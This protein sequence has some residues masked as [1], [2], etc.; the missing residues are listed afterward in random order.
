MV[1]MPPVS[2]AQNSS[3]FVPMSRSQLVMPIA[4]IT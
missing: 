2:P 1:R 3:T 4:F